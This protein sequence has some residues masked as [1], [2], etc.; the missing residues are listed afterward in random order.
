M[1]GSVDTANMWKWILPVLLLLLVAVGLLFWPWSPPPVVG[2]EKEADAPVPD[3]FPAEKGVPVRSN[4]RV[5]VARDETG[6]PAITTVPVPAPTLPESLPPSFVEFAA[7]KNRPA[8]EGDKAAW[9]EEGVRLAAARRQALGEL[10]AADPATALALALTEHELAQLPPAVRE[11]MESIVAAEGDFNV[12]AICH[13]GEGEE[14]GVTCEIQREVVLGMGTFEAEV[15]Q[16]SIYGSR[17]ER[18]TEEKASLY[19]VALD[20]VLALHEDDFVVLPASRVT[21]EEVP[22]GAL[23]LIYKGRTVIVP[24]P[25]ELES[26]A[27]NLLREESQG[28]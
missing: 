3:G 28:S 18:L 27:E 26:A 2:E 16:A 1:V 22:P 23:A 25:A 4:L 13:H 20:G 8:A 6:T 9:V 11:Q 24:D 17:A 5:L 10:I 15:Y 19:G 21:A 7:W 14:H 12:M